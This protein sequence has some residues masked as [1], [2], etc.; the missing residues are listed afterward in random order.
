MFTGIV[1]EKGK[2]LACE[3]REGSWRYR[4]AVEVVAS[5]VSL[6][7]S[8]AVNGCCLTVVEIGEG[9]LS[10][11]VLEETRRVTNLRDIA[12][13][14]SV[15]LERSLRFDG[16]VGG[17]FVTGHVDGAGVIKTLRPEGKDVLLEIEAPEG[18]EKYLVY[19]GCIAID[20]MSLTVAKV[21]GRVVTI[22]LIPHTL[23][24]TTIGERAAGDA[25]NLEFD[26]IAKYTE[27][28]VAQRAD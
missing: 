22:W 23:E 13:G 18:F 6:G 17:H 24:V 8:I 27:K 11:D 28:I 19:K 10:F 15:N 12:V 2:V 9:V 4:I 14:S 1:E 25:V 20:G 21:E 7:D 26:L 16:R 3:E 5:G